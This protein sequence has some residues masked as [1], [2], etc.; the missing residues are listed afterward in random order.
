MSEDDAD[1]GDVATIQAT[2]LNEPD[3][4]AASFTYNHLGQRVSKTTGTSPNEVTT[5]FIYD[6]KGN[7]ISELDT[8]GNTLTD[9][10]YLEG[11]R[12]AIVEGNGSTE[13]IY[14]TMN[15]HLGQTYALTNNDGTSSTIV[16]PSVS[17]NRE[18]IA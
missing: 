10:I 1:T 11:Q 14:F 18:L 9:Y 12:I 13:D 2:F 6:E 5:Y 17:L 7:L 15:D 8:N 3:P 4:V 16:L